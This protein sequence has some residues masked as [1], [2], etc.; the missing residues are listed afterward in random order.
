MVRDYMAAVSEWLELFFLPPCAP[1]LNPVELVWNDLKNHA[2]GH[3][4]IKGPD[5][6]KRAVISF[7]RHLQRT[8]DRFRSYFRAPSTRYATA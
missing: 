8:S 4:S 7:L 6:R 1:E 3:Q 5:Q 2:I